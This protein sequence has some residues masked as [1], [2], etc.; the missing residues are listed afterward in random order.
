MDEE[1]LYTPIQKLKEHLNDNCFFI[2]RD[3]LIP[4][5][6]GGNK[7]RKSILFFRELEKQEADYVVTYGSS[8]SNHCR[9]IANM[10][11]IRKIP[12]L[13][14]SPLENNNM[15]MN[16]MMMTLFGAEFIYCHVTEVSK[17]I[18]NSLNILRRKGWNPYFIEGGGHGNTGTQAYVNAF[19][20]ILKYEQDHEMQ[21]NYIFHTSGTGS[22]QAGLICGKKINQTKHKIIGISNARRN[23]GGKQVIQDS[24]NSYLQKNGYIIESKNDVDFIDDYILGGYGDYNTEILNVIKSVFIKDGIPLDPIYT[25]KGYAGMLRYIQDNNIQNQ[26]ILFIHTGGT[27]LFSDA[28]EEIVNGKGN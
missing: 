23:P 6:F 28:L 11:A 5:S 22:T 9:V 8:S 17:T 13:I 16:K 2:K 1:F 19:E 24:V 18:E 4:F 14:I 27:P 26:D 25:G 20:E 7:V 3:D 15:T 12:C 21:F 10:A